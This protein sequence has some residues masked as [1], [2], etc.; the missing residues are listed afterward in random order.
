MNRRWNWAVWVGFLLVVV[1][2]LSYPTFFALFPVTRD[3][4]WANLLIL[5]V[6]LLLLGL[7]LARA[8]RRPEVYRGKV[9]A[10]VLALLGVAGVCFF[11]FG[12]FYMARQLPAS[13]EAPHVG[14]KAPQF[15]LPDQDGKPVALA[16]LLATSPQGADA[17]KPGSGVLL[18]FYEG[19]WCPLCASE[20]RQF[21][22]RLSE[23]DARGVR[24]VGISNDPPEVSRSF[25]QKLGLGFP[26]LSDPR[27]EVIRRYDLLHAGAG[28]GGADVARSAEF[29]V[30]PDGT[31]RWVNLTKSI[32]VRARPAQVLSAFDQSTW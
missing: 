21:Q 17:G 32:T 15:T 9:F 13:A 7:G 11:C 6:G 4:P 27:A 19:Y 26:L 3:F 16:E 30:S 29:L 8:W 12:I 28:E 25:R 20:M 5:A 18:I 1:G 10:P 22:S 23:F 31:V 14:Q 2:F 24:V